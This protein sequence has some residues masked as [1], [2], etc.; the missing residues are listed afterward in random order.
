MHDRHRQLLRVSLLV[1]FASFLLAA[2]STGPGSGGVIEGTEWI[3]RSYADGDTLAIVPETQYAD[4]EF[5]R[6]RVTGLSGCNNYDA[7]YRQ[8]GRTLLVSQP[9]VTLMA[10][11][12]E[13][14][15]FEQTF[16]T[17]LQ[18]SRFYS[19]KRETL[20]IFG[21]KGATLLV[22]DAAPRNPLLGTWDVTSYADGTSVV[23]TPE[24]VRLEVVFG[25][26]SVGGF[27]G[28]NSFSGTYGTNGNYVRISRLA[29]TRVACDESVM[30]V[31]AAFLKALEGTSFLDRRADQMVLTDRDGSI[32]VSLARPQPEAAASPS[33]SPSTEPTEKPTPSET[34]EPTAT[35]KPTATA[36][37]TNAPTE[38]PSPTTAP[39]AA[40][41]VPP[42]IL[43]ALS[44]CELQGDGTTLATISYAA[45]WSTVSEP[46]DLACRYFDRDPITVPSDPATLKTAIIVSTSTKAYSEVVAEAQDTAAWTVRQTVDLQI[47]GLPA[48]M[49]EGET[50]VA[51]DGLEAGSSRLAYI[52]DY[53]SA[54]TMTLFTV[55]TAGDEIYAANAAVLTLMVGASTFTAPS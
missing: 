50:K 10:C 42:I 26:A 12:E 35:P 37:P 41:S 44:T 52:I 28:C 18:A 5:N 9:S 3:L 11:D 21:A 36:K 24:D 19:V 8:G 40:P 34:A 25:L 32:T 48:T 29:T 55:G 30:A 16:I 14:M 31:E 27:S 4:A 53:G 17:N 15:A 7:L 49:V 13:S 45:A 43:P 33:P 38:A 6:S 22:F 1:A 51:T 46:A 20:T 47:D 23:S 2:C 39:T 54:G